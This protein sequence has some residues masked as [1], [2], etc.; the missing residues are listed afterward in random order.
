MIEMG[1][2]TP[3]GTGKAIAEGL[4][5]SGAALEKFKAI[6]QAQGGMREP[7]RARHTHVVDATRAGVV[8]AFDNRRLARIA[9]LAGAPRAPAAGLELH[10]PLGT[11]LNRGDPLITI[12]A[13]TPGE[14][15]YAR[16]YLRANPQII[17]LD[18]T[19]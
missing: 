12:H 15:E 19:A 11:K 3:I 4:L 1:G 9:K 18:G 14:L 6:C 2:T 13:E 17:S 16:A 5:E 10:A 8:A 7:A